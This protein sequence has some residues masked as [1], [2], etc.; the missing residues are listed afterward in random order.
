MIERQTHQSPANNRTFRVALTGDFLDEWGQPAYGDLGLPL[1][2]DAPH[3]HYHFLLDQAPREN[4][5]YWRN[6]YS[7]QVE[8]RHIADIDGLIVLR[9]WVKCET[10]AH[11]AGNLTVIGRSGAGY[12][13]ID[14]AACTAN[15]VALFNAPFGLHHATASSA[16][17]FMLALVKRLPEQERAARTGD[18]RQQSRIMGSE[19]LGR[20][21]GIVGLGNSGRELARLVAPFEMTVLAY[22]PHAESAQ[23]AKLGVRLVSL[24]ELMRQADFVSLHSRLTPE[25]RG[26]IGARHLNLMKPTAFFINVARG[27]LVDQA[28]LV[29]LLRQRHIAG[30]ALDVFEHEPLPADDPLTTLDNVILT[31][32]WNASTT[33]VWRATGRAMALGILHVSRGEMPDN[34]VNAEVLDRPGFIKKLSRF[35][36]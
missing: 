34:V 20:T 5:D 31:P 12:D 14:V 26:M 25:S 7:M 16:L 19:L 32:H 18:W 36:R 15:D 29:E 17:L 13:K 23:A 21:L 1:W 9:P 28:A 2:N 35:S 27:E 6:L 3:I 24:D 8:P 30:A 22:S 11:G 4:A 10:F 33:D